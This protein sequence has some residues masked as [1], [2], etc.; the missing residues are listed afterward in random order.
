[1]KIGSLKTSIQVKDTHI[2][3]CFNH[4]ENIKVKGLTLEG[5]V[6]E[7]HVVSSYTDLLHRK[8]V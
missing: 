7:I 2:L 3:K 4:R 8:K 5:I 6:L 1:M